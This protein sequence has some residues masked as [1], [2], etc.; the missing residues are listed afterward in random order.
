MALVLSRK[1]MTQV[2]IDGPCTITVMRARDGTAR[3]S[4]EA[5][6][7]V[8]ITRPDAHKQTPPEDTP[9]RRA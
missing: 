2:V 5:D 8:N 7:S 9:D 6:R 3:L 1:E 4:F